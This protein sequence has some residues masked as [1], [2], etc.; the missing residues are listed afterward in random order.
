MGLNSTIWVTAHGRVG[1]LFQITQNTQTRTLDVS[2]FSH[3]YWLFDPTP[4]LL[5]AGGEQLM[6]ALVPY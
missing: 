6:V 2:G 1:E 4:Y 5:M 3:K